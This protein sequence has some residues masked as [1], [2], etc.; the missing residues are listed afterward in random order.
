MVAFFF[1]FSFHLR[2]TS[3]P[4]TP[5][6]TPLPTPSPTP[7]PTPSPTPKP[8][9][10][11]TPKPMPNSTATSSTRFSHSGA[12][13]DLTTP[14]SFDTTLVAII[15]CVVVL[16]LGVSVCVVGCFLARQRKTHAEAQHTSA[17]SIPSSNSKIVCCIAR[18]LIVVC[19]QTT[20]CRQSI[21]VTMHT[22]TCCCNDFL[23]LNN[24][25]RCQ[26]QRPITTKTWNQSTSNWNSVRGPKY[27]VRVTS[28]VDASAR[29]R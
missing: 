15:L 10:N 25:H 29:T 9:P 16:I 26:P 19:L 24:I 13:S 27:L 21:I 18:F 5:S 2:Q 3:C 17:E 7:L 12:P 8:T 23:Q 14:A 1:F 20:C 4:S 11:P 28:S 6:P 22:N